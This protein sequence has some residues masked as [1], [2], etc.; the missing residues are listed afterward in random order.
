VPT[1]AVVFCC[2]QAHT[3]CAGPTTLGRTM[4]RFSI[5][6]ATSIGIL[7]AVFAG[8][9]MEAADALTV[10]KIVAAFLIGFYC[11]FVAF[12]S[13]GKKRTLSL[14]AQTMLGVATSVLIAALLGA[15]TDGYLLAIAL[16]LL[17]GYTADLWVEHVQLP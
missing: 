7:F 1:A 9:R 14:A 15:S 16:G 3:A 4:D 8:W 17:L 6:L 10:R 5:L 11:A 13:M 2:Q 12:G